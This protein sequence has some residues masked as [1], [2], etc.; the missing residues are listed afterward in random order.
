MKNVESLLMKKRGVHFA[1]K[2]HM[3]FFSVK[4]GKIPYAIVSVFKI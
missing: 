2:A 1:P 3:Y 4:S